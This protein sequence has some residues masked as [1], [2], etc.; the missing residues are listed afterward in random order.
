MNRPISLLSMGLVALLLAAAYAPAA[1]ADPMRR[2]TSVRLSAPKL[3]AS[4]PRSLSG[5]RGIRM[6]TPRPQGLRAPRDFGGASRTPGGLRF[7]DS[8][9]RSRGLNGNLFNGNYGRYGIAEQLFRAYH[10]G[11]DRDPYDDIADAYRDAAIANAV[12]NM[13]GI[14][15]NAAMQPRVVAQPAMMSTQAPVSVA[16][17]APAPP[18][19]LTGHV[20]RREVVV[21]EGH[22]EEYQVFVPEHTIAATGEVVEAHHETRRRWVPAVTEVREV[23]IPAR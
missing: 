20:E 10:R 16:Q 2:S 21:R 8:G 7:P 12:V 5:T 13:V 6:N 14:I 17:P 22:Y 23:W 19:G 11:Y 15:A 3:G 18:P 9:S 1:S 4:A